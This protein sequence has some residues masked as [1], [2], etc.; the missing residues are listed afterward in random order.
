MPNM[1]GA[2]VSDST[3][4][5][6]L[7]DKAEREADMEA[8]GEARDQAPPDM[9][10]LPAS[11]MEQGRHLRKKFQ[12]QKK[13]QARKEAQRKA[14]GPT[15]EEKQTEADAETGRLRMAAE[16]LQQ[17][18][19]D[20][21]SENKPKQ[22]KKQ[23]KLG[24]KMLLTTEAKLSSKE[25]AKL[26][27]LVGAGKGS[28]MRAFFKSQGQKMVINED[29]LKAD[30]VVI[31]SGCRNCECTIAATCCKVFVED[32]HDFTLRLNGKIITQTVEIDTCERAN[33][34]VGTKVGTLQVE[35][36]KK[37]NVLVTEKIFFPECAYMVWAGCFMLRMQ[38][39]EATIHCDFGLT[40]KLDKTIN[41]ERTQFKVWVNKLGRL[42]C[43][44]VIRLKNGFPSTKREDDEHLRREESK[45]MDL[46]ERMGVNVHRKGDRVGARVKPNAKCPCGSG[47]K[48]KKCCSNVSTASVLAA[49]SC[50][51]CAIPTAKAGNQKEQD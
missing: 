35:R 15:E 26:Q 39:E 33:V 21:A 23:V 34:V 22:P 45:L 40:Q 18:E 42:T 8:S 19:K 14:N 50:A 16:K 43:D 7:I 28:K 4:Q 25:S 49:P 51:E 12:L 11:Y 36:C 29:E 37:I 3:F 1:H 44:K 27:A 38:L 30:Q 24:G 48:F 32:C 6:A 13:L 46:A 9:T 20:L 10:Q 31:F 2:T 41:I 17:I 5:S 47:A